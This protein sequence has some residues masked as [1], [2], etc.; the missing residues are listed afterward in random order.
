MK[1]RIKVVGLAVL[2]SLLLVAA[3]IAVARFGFG[4]DVFDRSGWRYE[5]DGTVRY[6]DY[7]GKPLLG[8]QE[9]EGSTY[10][11]DPERAGE[12]RTGWLQLGAETYYLEENGLKTTG[13]VTLEGE[14]Y[15]FDDS[16]IMYTGWL[17]D[18]ANTYYLADSGV[19]HTGWLED[20]GSTYYLTDSGVMHIGWLDCEK[21]RFYFAQDGTMQTGWIET[22]AGICYLSETGAVTV[23]W[24]DTDEGRFYIDPDG[25]MHTGWLTV[26]EKTYFLTENGSV[27][28]GWLE[29][30]GKRYYFRP[31][32][33]MA[34]GRV[35]IDGTARYFT[36]KGEYFV[37]VNPWNPVPGDYEYNLVWFD[38]FQVDAAC[39]DEL[40][41]MRADC[42]AAGLAFQITSAYRG[43]NYQNTLFQRK[44]DRLM[45]AGYSR[46]A[47]ES[48]TSRSIAIPGTSEHQLGLAVDIKSGNATY[49]WLARNSWKYGFIMRYPSGATNLTGIYYEPWH[50]RYVGKELAEELYNLGLC[51]EAYMDMLTEQSA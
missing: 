22:E 18:G 35:E 15:F 45:N 36:S 25:T 20:G 5:E 43:Y 26:E 7:H 2:L 46:S 21:G 39:R 42:I 13:F 9:V 24:V 11:F 29:L 28:I 44:V 6:L 8:W 12:R 3:A 17:E 31:D 23:G 34:V 48:E 14:R 50:F 1:N 16:G 51:V 33:T 32:G 10:Y 41:Q 19:M 27:H 38:G 30:D 4:Y 49:S 47:A 37:L 40:A